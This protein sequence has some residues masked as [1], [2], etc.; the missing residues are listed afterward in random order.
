MKQL[1]II[2]SKSNLEKVPRNT[3]TDVLLI[4]RE[5][6]EMYDEIKFMNANGWKMNLLEI[7]PFVE[8]ANIAVREFYAK[9]LTK[10][11]EQ[12]YSQNQK[13]RG[14]LFFLDFTEASPFK[15][16]ITNRL[17]NLALYRYISKE[18]NYEKV[19][20]L[21]FDKL[22]SSA[23]TGKKTGIR[24]TYPL[25]FGYWLQALRF[26]IY[27]VTTKMLTKLLRIEKIVQKLDYMVFTI[28]PF[29]WLR[30]Y[31]DAPQDR[32]FPGLNKSIKNRNIGY[33]CWLEL[34]PLAF[35][36]NRAPIGQMIKNQRMEILSNSLKFR[37]L[38]ELFSIGTFFGLQKLLVTQISKNE[39]NFMGLN[40]LPILRDEISRSISGSEFPRSRLVSRSISRYLSNH[41][42]KGIVSRFENQP[43]DRAILRACINQAKSIGYWHSSLALCDNYL[44]L[45]NLDG[46]SKLT[47]VTTTNSLTRPDVMLYAN[48]ICRQTLLREGFKESQIYNCGPTRHL[49]VIGIAKE[50]RIEKNEQAASYI[51]SARSV[52]ISFSADPVASRLMLKSALKLCSSI[53]NMS[54]QIKTH[55][56]WNFTETELQ[57]FCHKFDLVKPM[58]MD[59]NENLY[60]QLAKSDL[61]ISSGTQLVFEAILL[62][63]TPVIFE[64]NS[65]FIPTN[66]SVFNE[67]CFLATNPKELENA[68]V[69]VVSQSQDYEKKKSAW[70]KFIN[71][72][73]GDLV[74]DLEYERFNKALMRITDASS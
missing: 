57:K 63:V 22:L 58:L 62:G 65:S 44:S 54:I 43:I 39:L 38:L 46:M 71:E 52:V 61:L 41:L 68:M 29:W 15:G 24:R 19:V 45:W 6:D 4:G 30:P 10:Y 20:V 17:F 50:L 13:I 9:Q 67:I 64:S 37:D 69:Q 42:I 35:I 18:T 33:L 56:A 1:Y 27:V 31:S 12:E 23:I 49:D 2:D 51:S 14:N 74:P 60:V 25:I 11:I 70:P 47:E 32:F 48:D 5:P 34:T 40:A 36:R 26:L 21:L 55:P 3:P 59:S 28:Y 16:K 7:E 53:E 73:F 8:R 66:F 72:V